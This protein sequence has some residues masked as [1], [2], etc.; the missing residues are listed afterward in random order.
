MNKTNEKIDTKAAP[1]YNLQDH[2]S[3]YSL[4]FVYRVF[5]LTSETAFIKLH[6]VVWECCNIDKKELGQETPRSSS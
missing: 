3:Y 1:G 4:G 5:G 2:S 6:A